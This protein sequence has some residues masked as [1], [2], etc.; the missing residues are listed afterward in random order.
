MAKEKK[1]NKISEVTITKTEW[2]SPKRRKVRT[3]NK[4]H[5]SSSYSKA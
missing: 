1:E 5:K 3:N 2:D 4:L